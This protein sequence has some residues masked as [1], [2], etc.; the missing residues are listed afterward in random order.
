MLAMEL[1]AVANW[2]GVY[3]RSSGAL[4]PRAGP[5]PLP[6]VVPPLDGMVVVVDVVVVDVDV[7]VDVVLVVE[8]VVVAP[9][10]LP[11]VPP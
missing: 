3:P 1:S 11:V 9:G 7:V 5:D 10:A 6:G 2:A 4:K 8:V